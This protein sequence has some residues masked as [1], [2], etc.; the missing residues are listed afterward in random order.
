MQL[1]LFHAVLKWGAAEEKR[2]AAVADK[3]KDKDKKES[4]AATK[5]E[6]LRDIL[7]HVRL[8]LLDMETLAGVVSPSG[9]I[10]PEHLVALFTYVGSKSDSKD[11]E[12]RSGWL[13]AAG[14]RRLMAISLCD[15]LARR[16]TR[17]SPAACPTRSTRGSDSHYCLFLCVGLTFSL[18]RAQR[19]S[20]PV[21]LLQMGREISVRR[22][23]CQLRRNGRPSHACT[24]LAIM[25]FVSVLC[26]WHRWVDT[27]PSGSRFA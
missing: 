11:G 19:A 24:R 22:R 25:W 9:V 7:P 10:P 13:L 18:Y 21:C 6:L 4:K 20:P 3:D 15:S 27:H 14:P 23:R 2:L 12:V 1:E 17:R 8:P 16:S 26:S 5:A